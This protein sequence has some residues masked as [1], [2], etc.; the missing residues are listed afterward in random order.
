M[1]NPF[2]FL[3]LH[4]IF[5]FGIIDAVIAMIY[6]FIVVYSAKLPY[7]KSPAKATV[8]IILPVFIVGFFASVFG[9]SSVFAGILVISTFILAS[10]YVAKIPWRDLVPIVVPVLFYLFVLFYIVGWLRIPL[11][12]IFAFLSYVQGKVIMGGKEKFEN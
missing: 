10:R 1:F 7:L 5:Y 9:F 2:D 3:M 12:L 11:M 8:D 6:W 4:D